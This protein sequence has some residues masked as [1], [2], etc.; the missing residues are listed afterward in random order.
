MSASTAFQK[1][2]GAVYQWNNDN[3]AGSANQKKTGVYTVEDK[4]GCAVTDSIRIF[5]SNQ[6]E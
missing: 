1:I 6:P 5:F 2:P 3:N 4:T